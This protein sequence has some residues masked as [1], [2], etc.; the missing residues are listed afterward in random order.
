MRASVLN[1][2]ALVKRAGQFAW[3]SID[4]DKPVNTE[5]SDKLAA[6]GVPVFAVIDSATE[7]VALSWYGSA[8]ATQLVALMDDGA[9]VISGGASGPEAILARADEANARKDYVNAAAFYEQALKAGGEKWAKRPRVLESLIMSQAFGHNQTACGETALREAPGMA[10]D[11]SFVNVVYFGLDCVKPGTAD[12]KEMMKLAEEAVKIPGVLSDDVS[13]LYG[14]LSYYYQKDPANAERVANDWVAYLRRELAQAKGPDARLALDLQLVSAANALHK[15][16]MAL[17][18]IQRAER[19]LPNEYMPPRTAASV[20]SQMGRF[21]D[22]M[23]ACGRALA[24]ADGDPKLRTYLMCGGILAKK[25]DKPAAKKM[26]DDGIAYGRTLP[27]GVGK[28][29]IQAL[30]TAASKL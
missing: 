29:A 3:L 15:P 26:Y 23:N 16:E 22:A 4:T 6:G 9:R 12:A 13:Q 2:A 24:R 5:V 10:R 27:A 7:K 14:S 17:P 20:Y 8:T 30:E 18:E 1:D 11:R 28:K 25:G 19:E 21:D